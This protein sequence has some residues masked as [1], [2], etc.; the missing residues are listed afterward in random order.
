M[1]TDQQSFKNF[2]LSSSFIT[3][4]AADNK[5]YTIHIKYIKIEIIDYQ[6]IINAD[7]SQV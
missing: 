1:Y 3:S 2:L 7:K 6:L 4:L 5:I